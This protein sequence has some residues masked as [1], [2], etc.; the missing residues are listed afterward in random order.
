MRALQLREKDLGGRAL[1]RR[2]QALVQLARSSGAVVLV[3]DRAD[4]ARAAG[5]AGVHLPEAGLDVRD[6]RSVLGAGALIGRSVHGPAALASARGADFVV[7]GPVYETPSKV[8]YG[9]PQGLA[10]LAAVCE[11]AGELPVLAI[12]GVTAD[13][14]DEVVAAGAA[15]VAVVSAVLRASDPG[16]AARS[17]IAALRR[18]LARR[19]TRDAGDLL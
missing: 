2:A 17:L 12:G 4:V 9:P 14:I 8:R 10:R 13:R 11:R 5:A 16:A 18:A 3:N 15:G 6:A 7:F 1:Y 19:V